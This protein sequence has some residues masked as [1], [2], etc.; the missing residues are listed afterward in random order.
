[1]PRRCPGGCSGTVFAREQDLL[2]H[3][4]ASTNPKCQEAAESLVSS[5]RRPIRHN[6]PI[7]ASPPSSPAAGAPSSHSD[8]L[9]PPPNDEPPAR[10]EGDYFGA[11]YQDEDFPFVAG[12]ENLAPQLPLRAEAPPP[13]VYEVDDD[14]PSDDEADLVGRDIVEPNIPPSPRPSPPPVHPPTPPSNGLLDLPPGAAQAEHLEHGGVPE[15]GGIV[16]DNPI[17]PE[18][19]GLL[20]EAPVH[21]DHFGGD[22]GTPIIDPATRTS[23]YSDY[24]SKVGDQDSSN[25]YAPFTSRTDWEVAQWAKE[26]GVSATAITELL[27]IHGVCILCCLHHDY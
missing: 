8:N 18:V 7:P 14:E 3:L 10:F 2:Q 6:H 11:D 17:Q 1:M 13:H 27:K 25:P 5:V 4:R 23:T 15:V 20:R 24:G 21:V 26:R 16:P 9:S 22:A 12:G 19:H